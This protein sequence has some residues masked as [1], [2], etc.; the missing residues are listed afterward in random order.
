MSLDIFI[1]NANFQKDIIQEYIFLLSFW[2]K[3]HA[4][5]LMKI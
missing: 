4:N 1:C 3:F 5:D 2:I